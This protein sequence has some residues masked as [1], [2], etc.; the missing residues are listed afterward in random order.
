[1][2]TTMPAP[3]T[4]MLAYRE[5]GEIDY[6]RLDYN[7][8]EL[9]LKPEAMEQEQPIQHLIGL[10]ASR[11][12]DFDRRPDTFLSSNTII[13]YD[14][15]NLNVRVSPDVYLAFGVEAH[16]IRSRK[17][18]LPWE[19]GKPPDWVLEVASSSTGPED[20]GR[21]RDLYARIGVPEYWRFDPKDGK[22][23]GQRLAGDRLVAG[24]Y[25]PIELTT[26]PDGILKGHSEIL[27]LSLCWDAGWPRLYDPATGSYL[28]NWREVWVAR[29]LAELRAAEAEFHVTA[30]E[31]RATKAETRAAE[32]ETHA[33]KAETRAA[34]AETHATAERDRRRAAESELQR[35]REQLRR[36]QAD[37]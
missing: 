1:M 8:D 13:C 37:R 21:K 2:T 26:A 25:E 22:Y 29:E 18:Y 6:A 35:L 11:F 3:T 34:E 27:G 23:H 33:T 15:R 20:V 10:L 30:A 5:Q 24:A 7:P 4:T 19:V 16:T 28:E 17:L 31:T 32:A 14:R 36:R 12:T 9:V